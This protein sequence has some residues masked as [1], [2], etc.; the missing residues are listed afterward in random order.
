MTT[1]TRIE[2]NRR[3]AIQSTGP[4]TIEGKSTA[5]RNAL[6]HG[7]LS[8]DLI[9]MDENPHDLKNLKLDIYQTLCPQGAIEGILVEKIINAIWRIRRLTKA[10]YGFLSERDSPFEHSGLSQGFRGSNGAGLQVLSRYEATLERSFY[11]ALHELQKIQ[12]MRLG[13]HV[14]APMSIDITND[15]EQKIGFDS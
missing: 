12:G 8:N 13:Y 9:I 11:R 3:N 5:S 10:E 1:M 15:T 6:K 2:S 14:L 7:V 4:K